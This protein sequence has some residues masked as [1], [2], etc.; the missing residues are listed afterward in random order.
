MEILKEKS[1]LRINEVL[2]GAGKDKGGTRTSAVTIGGENCLPFHLFEGEMPNPPKTAMEIWDMKPSDWPAAL[3]KPFDD[4]MD[5]PAKWAKKCVEQYGAEIIALRLQS[6]HPDFGDAGADKCAAAVRSVL[7]SVGV[8]LVIFGCGNDEKDNMI[9]PKC[10]ET[11]KGENCL[12]GNATQANYKT[13]TASCLADG[14]SI[15]GETPIDVNIQKQVNILVTE[16]GF[17]AKKIVMDPTTGG[18]G[19]G[20][21][22]T[23]SVMERI[24]SAALGGDST[25][26]MP[27]ICRAGQ[28]SW[29]AKESKAGVSE[30]PEWGDEAQ[31]GP[32]WEI[33]TG[34]PLLVAGADLLVV[35]HPESLAG[36]KGMIKH[37]MD[38]QE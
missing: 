35:R 23:Y 28:E 37:L 12:M 38:K 13:L 19:Y 22:Y 3:V 31:R 26:S 21:E 27:F 16:M 29:R 8:P 33:A 1:S 24:R 36:L 2:I 30:R 11:A 18:L 32:A 10:S 34:V 17:D 14:H 9:M 15:I 6:A 4:V 5:S 7:D 25:L 20:L